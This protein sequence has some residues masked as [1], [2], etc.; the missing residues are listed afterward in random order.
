MKAP[1]ETSGLTITLNNANPDL[2]AGD[3]VIMC[4]PGQSAIFQTA[5]MPSANSFTYDAS[6]SSPGNNSTNLDYTDAANPTGIQF[7]Q[8]SQ[9]SR[10][11]AVDWYV[12]NNG[13]GGTSLYR[14]SLQNVGGVPTET[15][16]EM[17]RNVS[18]MQITY[19]A[20]NFGTNGN[21]F[22]TA[23]TTTSDSAWG[24][25]SAVRV[26]LTTYSTFNRATVDAKSVSR[27]YSFTTTIRNRVD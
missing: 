22:Q 20:P 16:M 21:A 24:N 11:Q 2:Q 6:G 1:G 7:K 25:V 14:M 17:V 10:Y 5:T 23:A 18:N 12:G 13:V 19:L 9:V 27:T 26:V 4:D 3:I 8:N 15:A